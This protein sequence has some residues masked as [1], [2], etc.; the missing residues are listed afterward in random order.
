MATMNEARHVLASQLEAYYRSCGWRVR[1]ADDGT[2]EA[3]GTGGVTWHGAAIVAEDIQGTTALDAR[4]VE[5]A[6]R[7]MPGGGE[8]CPLDLLPDPEA[9]AGL[10]EALERTR[11]S[12]RPHVSVYELSAAA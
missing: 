6:N 5:L 4:L 2:L 7:R 11:L 10:R 12:H 8:L 3:D 1:R 9:E